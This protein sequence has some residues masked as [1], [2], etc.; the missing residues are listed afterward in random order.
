TYSELRS[1]CAS[2]SPRMPSAYGCLSSED[3]MAYDVPPPEQCPE[4]GYS[5][6]YK[7][8]PN[9]PLNNYAYYIY[10]VGYHTEDDCRPEDAFMQVYRPLYEAAYVYRNG[11]MFD[12]RPLHMFFKPAEWQ[13]RM[14]P[15]FTRITD[16]GVVAELD[17][18]K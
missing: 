8:D 13:G 4:P 15:R 17:R 3:A 9:G 18:L 12:L 1:R 7:H 11:G 6:Y 2:Q 16:P 14:V 5:Y 10:G